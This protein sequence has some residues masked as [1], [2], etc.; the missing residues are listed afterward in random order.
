MKE[1]LKVWLAGKGI[2]VQDFGTH[3]ERAVDYPDY[4]HA[5]ASVVGIIDLII[6]RRQRVIGGGLR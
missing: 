6:T 5:V 1:K 3:D 2:E 4:A